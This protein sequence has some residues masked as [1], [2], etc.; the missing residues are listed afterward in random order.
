MICGAV[1]IF[2]GQLHENIAGV[3]VI[4]DH[5]GLQ[6]LP[7]SGWNAAEAVWLLPARVYDAYQNTWPLADGWQRRTNV[8]LCSYHLLNHLNMFGGGYLD[9]CH[10]VAGEILLAK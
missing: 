2:F 3:P 7:R 1:I 5:C 10:R 8:T 6:W 9:Q 4:I